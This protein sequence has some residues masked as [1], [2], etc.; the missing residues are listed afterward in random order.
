V[1]LD[2]VDIYN[3]NPSSEVSTHSGKI[4]RDNKDEILIN[5]GLNFYIL[6]FNSSLQKF[7]TIF[8]KP[9]INSTN[10]IVYDFDKNGINEIG[11]NT[12]QDSLI[13]FEK[14]IPFF[15]GPVTPLNLNAF[16][17]DSNKVSVNFDLVTGAEYYRIY[18]ADNDSLQN[19]ILYDSVSSNTFFDNNVIN[20]KNYYYKVSSIDLNNIVQESKLTS[21]VSVFVHNKSRLVSAV[22]NNNGFLELGF[23]QKLNLL[24]PNMNSVVVNNIGNPVSIGIKSPHEYFVS[25]GNRIPNGNYFV[26]TN[27]LKDFYGSPVDTNTLSFAV[28]QIDTTTF[29]VK[30]A[31]LIDKLRLK[32]EFNLNVDSVSVRNVNNYTFEPFAFNIASVDLDNSN[33]NIIYLNITGRGTIGASGRNYFLRVSN[34]YSFNGIKIIDGAGSSFGLSFVKEN[35]NDVVVYPNPYTIKSNQGF[36]TFANLT[37]TATIYIYDLTGVYIASVTTNSNNGGVQ[38]NLKTNRGGD[39]TT[40][41]YLFRAEGKDSN[42]N[43]VPEKIGK[44]MVI[45]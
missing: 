26:K 4:D 7:E 28:N 2:R 43:D 6:K 12:S 32:V 34:V 45:K 15:A 33:K 19:F 23:S 42:G 36:I 13:F 29:Y 44:F 8:Y 16:S 3:Y 40:G 22:Y 14:D 37:K 30:N 25:Y 1:I 9:S 18:R 39:I 35:L 20:K 10:Q 38:W 27:G 41:I 21:V 24:I 17:I 31:S 11:I 5:C